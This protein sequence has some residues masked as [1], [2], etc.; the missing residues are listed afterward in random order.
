MYYHCFPAGKWI[1]SC[2]LVRCAFLFFVY[3]FLFLSSRYERR[4]ELSVE[5]G[6]D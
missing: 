5:D 1:V 3:N 2:L 4:D 6:R